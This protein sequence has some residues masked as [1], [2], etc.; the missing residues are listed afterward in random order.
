MDTI[1]TTTITVQ[2]YKN[3]K[4]Y[5]ALNTIKYSK[6]SRSLVSEDGFKNF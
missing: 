2:F 1:A 5:P 6:K 4:Y 3:M